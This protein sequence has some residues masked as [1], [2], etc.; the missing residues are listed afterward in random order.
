MSSNV[1]GNNALAGYNDLFS[2]TVDTPTAEPTNTDTDTHGERIVEIPLTE[3]YPPEFHPFHVVDDE[4]MERLA[5]NIKQYG[6]REPGL[7]R[8]RTDGGYELLAGNRRKR[9]SE[10]AVL[11]RTRPGSRTPY[12]L[13]F[14][15]NRSIASSSFTW[16]G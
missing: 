16:N 8:P 14:N 4:A 9:A 10:L 12:C 1:L 5:A 6:V 3:L 11:G 13:M 7:A 2:S 15:V